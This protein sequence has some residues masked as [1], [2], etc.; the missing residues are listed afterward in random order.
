MLSVAAPHEEFA[1]RGVPGGRGGSL[2]GHEWCCD[3]LLRYGGPAPASTERSVDRVLRRHYRGNPVAKRMFQAVG[4]H[5]RHGVVNPLVEDVSGWSTSPADERYL[6]EALPLGKEA[7]AAALAAAGL[8]RRG[9]RHAGRRL[10]HGLRDPGPQHPARPRPRHERRPADACCS[11]TWAATPPCPAL[12]AAADYVR[13]HRRP[14]LV[15]CLE[16]TSLHLQP[17]DLPAYALT[18]DVVQQ[19]IVHALFAD[20]AAAVVVT[21]DVGAADSRSSTSPRSRTPRPPT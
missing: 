12:G 21:P 11:G 15:L 3:H 1:S 18:P 2:I 7:I 9:P 20:A 5:T 16:L 4:V 6:V 17:S 14:A 19:M 8:L 10:L 13:L